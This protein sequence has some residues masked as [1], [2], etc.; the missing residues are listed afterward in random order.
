[1][2]ASAPNPSANLVKNLLRTLISS[3]TSTSHSGETSKKAHTFFEF[4]CAFF[5]RPTLM[6]MR[7]EKFR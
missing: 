4:P 1:M 6:Q 3:L 7:P 5:E 2:P